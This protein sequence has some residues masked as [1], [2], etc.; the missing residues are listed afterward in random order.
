MSDEMINVPR[1]KKE[2]K[3]EKAE[4][5]KREKNPWDLLPA[6]EEYA[7]NGFDSI[8]PDDLNARFR[9]WG[10]YTQGD[11][12]G[13]MGGAV[14][15]FM[16]R[17]RIANGQLFSHQLRLISE[18]AE[19]HAHGFGD[20]TVR[21]NI[22]LHWV[23]IEEIPEIWRNLW[24]QSLMTTGA[25]G[26][27]TRNITGCPLAGVDH[28]EI[29][30]ASPLTHEATRMLVGNNDFYNLPRKYKISISGCRDWCNLPEIND[31]ALN[32]VPHPQRDEIGFSIRVGGGLSVNPHYAVHLNAFVKWDQ[33]IPV[34][35]GVSEIFRDS[36][37]LR[38]SRSAARLKFL[39][40]KFGWTPDT[41]LEELHRRIGFELEP[42]VPETVPTDTW[43]DHVGIHRQKQEGLNYVGA[44]VLRGRITADQ[45]KLV[46]D[47]SEEYG[48]RQIRL[49]VGQNLVLTDI[50]DENVE[51]VVQKLEAA[52]LKTKA[53]SFWRGTVACTGM[54]FCKLSLTETKGYGAWLVDEMEKRM[55]DFSTKLRI[56]VNGCPN[57]CGQHWIA[58]IGLQ[59]RKAKVDGKQ[60]DAYDL[61]L[62]GGTGENP[63]LARRVGLAVPAQ[64]L[65]DALERLL[66]GY[67]ANRQNGESLK[68]YLNREEDEVLAGLLHVGREH[69]SEE[70]LHA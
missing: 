10:L 6:I 2:S 30:D 24:K 44:S 46:A 18:I 66:N 67:E 12:K 68:Q 11:G 47:L 13:V 49:T 56:N 61:F 38:E 35:H 48:R 65:P 42:A 58:D 34:V 5:L 21:E 31:L 15:H 8:D 55:P 39:F 63:T 43:R 3:A 59:G 17:I 52:D 64:Q 60:V 32:A 51:A 25:C 37:I 23:S 36:D 57:S 19:K 26:D 1:A 9:W 27:V 62:G 4:R 29:V 50:P 53:S 7:R 28:N 20:I 41:F 40:L 69:K 54:E 33:V 22:Q 70:A 45:M 16:M 14:P